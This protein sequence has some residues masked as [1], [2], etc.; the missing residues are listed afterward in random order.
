[1]MRLPMPARSELPPS[2][3][4]LMASPHPSGAGPGPLRPSTRRPRPSEQVLFVLPVP[5]HDALARAGA[6]IGARRAFR[7]GCLRGRVDRFARLALF[8]PVVDHLL[9]I[10]EGV[11]E[12]LLLALAAERLVADG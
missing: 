1:M 10:A 11:V 6:V 4:I 3:P 12:R 8:A 5:A 2:A 9:A 7:V